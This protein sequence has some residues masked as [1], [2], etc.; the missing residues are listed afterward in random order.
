[1]KEE[2]EHEHWDQV[3]RPES[4][5]FSLKLREVWEYRDLL[6]LLVKR[7]V[8]SFYKQTVLGP[9]W[10]FIQPLIM[11]PGHDSWPSGHATESFLI[12]RLLS[13]FAKGSG[14]GADVEPQMMAIAQRIAENREVAG[15]HF[16]ADSTAGRVLGDT[17]ARF[18]LSYSP[19]FVP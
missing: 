12:A 5:V 8:V 9:L 15:V 13:R 11:T 19:D 1:M 3:I 7:D 18:V 6:V 17:L 14:G 2:K 10:F 4:P 16:L